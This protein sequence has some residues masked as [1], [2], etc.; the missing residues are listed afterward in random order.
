MLSFVNGLKLFVLLCV[1]GIASVG[2]GLYLDNL[3]FWLISDVYVIVI[4]GL[5]I[6]VLYKAAVIIKTLL[7]FLQ[8]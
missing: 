5:H 4:L 3:T 2:V 6:P 8:K 7:T 1:G